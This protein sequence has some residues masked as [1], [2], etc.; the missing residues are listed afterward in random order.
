MTASREAA[1][2]ILAYVIPINNI[3]LQEYILAV[4]LFLPR[5]LATCILVGAEGKAVLKSV[6]VVAGCRRNRHMQVTGIGGARVPSRR[7]CNSYERRRA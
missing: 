4:L 6:L 1:L 5:Q 2:Y 3:F 7:N